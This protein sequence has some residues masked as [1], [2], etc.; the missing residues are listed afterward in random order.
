MMKPLY[1]KPGIKEP[2]SQ[3]KAFIVAFQ[4]ADGRELTTGQIAEMTGSVISSAYRLMD[5]GSR[6]TPICRRNWVWRSLK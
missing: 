1:T 5:K 6:V 2:T 3:E 4:L